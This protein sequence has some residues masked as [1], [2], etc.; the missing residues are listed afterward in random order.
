MRS[1]LDKNTPGHFGLSG[2]FRL[3]AIHHR[4]KCREHNLL[5][6]LME[7]L[8]KI[9]LSRICFSR[10]PTITTILPI[11]RLQSQTGTRFGLFVSKQ[12]VAEKSDRESSQAN[13]GPP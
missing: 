11:P 5:K 3:S 6:I 8:L 9:P 4:Q 13:H 12:V 2:N 10:I 1:L 7:W